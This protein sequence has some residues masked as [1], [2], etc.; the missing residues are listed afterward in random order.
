MTPYADHLAGDTL[1]WQGQ[2]AGRKDALIIA[3]EQQQRELLVFYRRTK[4]EY[5]G[6]GFR[7]EGCFRYR[8]HSGGRHT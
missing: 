3:H 2:L 7:Y 1:S 8:S 6:S 5:P 4:T